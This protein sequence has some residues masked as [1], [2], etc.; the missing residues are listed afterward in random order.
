MGLNKSKGNMYPFVNSTYNTVK[1]LC[2]H[3]CSYCYMK[4]WKN[5]KAVRFDEK[6]L[7]T[8]LGRGNFIFVGSSNDLFAESINSEWIS[9][10]LEHCSKFNNKYLFQSKN[11]ERMKDFINEFP[12]D[13]VLCTTI[14]TNRYF[15]NIMQ[16]APLPEERAK[17]M[18]SIIEF[19][20]HITVEPILRFDLVELVELIRSC[21]VSQ[22]NIGADSGGH[23]M[24]EPSKE[25]VVALIQQLE[26][27][28]NVYQKKN[29]KRLLK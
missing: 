25:H 7:K 10:T 26:Q 8:D 5:Q 2:S 29:L 15:P 23:H 11:P 17:A 28:T 24:P 4:R 21:S 18:A 19:E 12:E 13:T 14:E 20:K 22:V 6:E 16:N 27:F 9:K 1:G 3:D